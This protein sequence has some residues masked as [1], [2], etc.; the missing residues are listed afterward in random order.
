[1]FPHQLGTAVTV[2]YLP[3]PDTRYWPRTRRRISPP[4]RGGR[5]RGRIANFKGLAVVTLITSSK[6]DRD[7]KLLRA[8][9]R[10]FIAVA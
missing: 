9:L 2:K 6:F 10:R 3:V 8:R 4:L 7:D 5:E 1:M